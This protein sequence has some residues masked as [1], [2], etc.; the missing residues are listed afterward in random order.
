[1][2]SLNNT[3][4]VRKS[5]VYFPQGCLFVYWS[6]ISS[7]AL[8]HFHIIFHLWALIHLYIAPACHTLLCMT[9]RPLFECFF[10]PGDNHYL[11]IAQMN[12]PSNY[13]Y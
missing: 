10:K 3:K 4:E 7:L 13:Y 2:Q 1:M 11:V 5:N 12:F 9:D 6:H 8:C